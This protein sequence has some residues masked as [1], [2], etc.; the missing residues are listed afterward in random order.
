MD[1]YGLGA[2]AAGLLAAVETGDAMVDDI[3][4]EPPLND[5][6][7][8]RLGLGISIDERIALARRQVLA[9][10]GRE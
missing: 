5:E 7:K 1:E 4:F 9:R 8:R 6:E 3:V 2:E 10:E